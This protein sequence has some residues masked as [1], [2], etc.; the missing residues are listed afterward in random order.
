[1]LTNYSFSSAAVKY[2]SFLGD[3][4]KEMSKVEKR[5]RVKAANRVR[6][7]LRK[8]TALKFGA[9]SDITKG[10]GSRNMKNTSIVGVGPPAQAAHL[11]E[12]GTDERYQLS[13]KYT[14][15]INP[16]PFVFPTYVKMVPEVR[17]ILS[18]EWF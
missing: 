2:K 3:V 13:G 10:V 8:V 6:K 18:E 17:R 1:M 16:D 9:G 15:R 11:I 7:E 12:F 14:G 5:Q 4:E